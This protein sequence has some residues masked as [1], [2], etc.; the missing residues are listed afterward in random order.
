MRRTE[1]ALA[2][3]L[4]AGLA[5][6][7]VTTATA[8]GVV[9]DSSSRVVPGAAV[10]LRRIATGERRAVVTDGEG[11]YVAADL[12]LGTYEIQAERD[13]FQTEVRSG[14][15]LTVGREAVVDFVLKVG[16]IKEKGGGDGRSSPG[17]YSEHVDGQ[18]GR[19]A[20]DGR[21]S[22][23]RPRLYAI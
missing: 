16:T 10:T 19:P 21:P 4:A 15:E 22:A 12:P 9:E 20:D 3:L 2:F 17:G 1:Y 7:Q 8:S 14:I 23:Q 6:A 18:R 11:G 13:G 5:P